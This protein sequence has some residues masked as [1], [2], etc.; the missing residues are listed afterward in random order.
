MLTFALIICFYDSELLQ[1]ET[2]AD[3]TSGKCR[4]KCIHK[5]WRFVWPML[6]LLTFF[7]RSSEGTKCKAADP[8]DPAALIAEALKKKFAYRYRSDSQSETEKAIPKTE[9]KTKTEVVLVSI[10]ILNRFGINPSFL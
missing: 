5:F 8:A 2:G 3:V 10:V 4:I 9:T 6:M 1:G 7:S